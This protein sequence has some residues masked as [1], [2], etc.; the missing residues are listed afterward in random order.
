MVCILCKNRIGINVII[1]AA[2]FSFTHAHAHAHTNMNGEWHWRIPQLLHP[3]MSSLSKN[4][5]ILVQVDPLQVL[6]VWKV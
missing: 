3:H 2:C 5:N 4:I 1:T 6:S